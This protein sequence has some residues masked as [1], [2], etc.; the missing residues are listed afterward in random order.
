MSARRSPE[1]G[2]SPVPASFLAAPAATVITATTRGRSPVS[3]L[4]T[5]ARGRSPD[6]QFLGSSNARGKSP[7]A[8]FDTNSLW[9]QLFGLSPTRKHVV[10]LVG[11]GGKTSTMF[12]LAKECSLRGQKVICTTTTKIGAPSK[13]LSPVLLIAPT[14]QEMV[15]KLGRHLVPGEICTVAYGSVR[16][17]HD[18]TLMKLVGI[19]AE[20]V[21]TLRDFADVV[22]IEADGAAH[23]PF[24]MPAGHEPV[25]PSC[26]TE[27]LVLIGTDALGAPIQMGSVHRPELLTAALG[28]PKGTPLTASMIARVACSPVG[29]LKGYPTF[30]SP[31]TPA[32]S[33]VVVAPSSPAS[34]TPLTPTSLVSPPLTPTG[35]TSFSVSPPATP[36]QLLRQS[37][38]PLPCRLV[39]I[40]NKADINPAGAVELAQAL[41]S[42]S[43]MPDL[44]LGSSGKTEGVHLRWDRILVATLR[45]VPT[46][47]SV[48]HRLFSWFCGC[49]FVL[50][51]DD[52]KKLLEHLDELESAANAK[53]IPIFDPME[54][55]VP[56]TIENHPPS[57][58]VPRLPHLS[59][60]AGF[61]YSSFDPEIV[62][63]VSVDTLI[64]ILD[65]LQVCPRH[66]P[67]SSADAEMRRKR[68]EQQALRD[69]EALEQTQAIPP[70]PLP[71]PELLEFVV[72]PA[73]RPPLT[74]RL[75]NPKSK[76]AIAQRSS[77]PSLAED[78]APDEAATPDPPMVGPPPT[79]G[80]PAP[81]FSP[82]MLQP[83]RLLAHRPSRMA[84]D[85]PSVRTR[86]Q[87]PTTSCPFGTWATSP[88]AA[89]F[90]VA[91]C[92]PLRIQR[93]APPDE[94]VAPVA[95][96][97][98]LVKEP[99]SAPP[100]LPSPAAASS[101]P[102]TPRPM[103]PGAN[104]KACPVSRPL[105]LYT[106][107]DRALPGE[108]PAAPPPPPPGGFPMDDLPPP[109]TAS[110]KCK[111]GR[112]SRADRG[113]GPRGPRGG[114]HGGRS[115]MDEAAAG[116]PGDLT[117]FGSAPVAAWLRTGVQQAIH[118]A[119]VRHCGSNGEEQAM[120]IMA[121]MAENELALRTAADPRG[122]LRAQCHMEVAMLEQVLCGADPESRAHFDALMG[123]LAAG[124]E[125]MVRPPSPQQP[126][127]Q[128]LP[129]PH[130]GRQDDVLRLY[131]PEEPFG[132]PPDSPPPSSPA[133]APAPAPL[134]LAPPTLLAPVRVPVPAPA[135]T[136][137]TTMRAP[138]PAPAPALASAA[139]HTL[140][141]APTHA[142]SPS[143]SPSPTPAPA[144]HVVS[145]IRPI[146]IT[147][148]L[149]IPELIVP[150]PPP[151]PVHAAH[152]PHPA[153]SRQ[154]LPAHQPARTAPSFATPPN[155]EGLE[156]A[157]PTPQQP[158]QPLALSRPPRAARRGSCADHRPGL[159]GHARFRHPPPVAGRGS[160]SAFARPA[161][162]GGSLP[163]RRRPNTGHRR[164]LSQARG[165]TTIHPACPWATHGPTRA[166]SCPDL[167]WGAPSVDAGRVAR[168]AGGTAVPLPMP[169]CPWNLATL[170]M[171]LTFMQLAILPTG[172]PALLFHSWPHR[173]EE[174]A[175]HAEAF[176]GAVR[177][178]RFTASA[179]HLRGARLAE[180]LVLALV[181]ALERTH[182]EAKLVAG[183]QVLPPPDQALVAPIFPVPGPE[184][185]AAPPPAGLTDAAVLGVTSSLI[186]ALLQQQQQ[187]QHQQQQQQPVAP[188]GSALISPPP[189]QVALPHLS[190][191]GSRRELPLVELER[192]YARGL[193][194]DTP[195][196]RS[197]YLRTHTRARPLD[198][199]QDE[200][201]RRQLFEAQAAQAESW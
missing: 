61:F 107:L 162:R 57:V 38:I 185:L 117:D 140:A 94:R 114:W 151:A 87:S 156:R 194:E 176:S 6:S 159:A 88:A 200:I 7:D 180:G 131:D 1:R 133:P 163:A 168:A 32:P 101:R 42:H 56:D 147:A 63:F 183:H 167:G 96:D 26:T 70:Q 48:L 18:P 170:L 128:R 97:G 191:E 69:L 186:Q 134:A 8:R 49:F 190:R 174:L 21:A 142:A 79:I 111:K 64:Q 192:L 72:D 85:G 132:E 198:A 173:D 110:R 178:E 43:P 136:P 20:W 74:I 112:R 126:P 122:L 113:R 47:V 144:P 41:W 171:I 195:E 4:A 138:A 123:S 19:P 121:A 77:S 12:A 16:A 68:C 27:M 155:H 78:V 58:P 175:K 145:P 29:L 166:P 90:T 150:L 146:P 93:F 17:P 124:T 34:L 36:T 52:A 44:S 104:R 25:V 189:D 125:Y 76:R 135:H 3:S 9:Q 181:R 179:E 105:V 45:P 149:P 141:H 55:L 2:R 23:L 137:P 81:V 118:E 201:R 80:A 108:V 172:A 35:M 153:S 75:P 62:S 182:L 102:R 82:L 148:C 51:P 99:P 187:Q 199:E 39:A 119:L 5:A 116:A 14:I 98:G 22:I 50:D 24:K 89:T 184:P 59:G 169:T 130:Q 13:D 54:G 40:V 129:L 158:Q 177:A 31:L 103:S 66:P 109:E 196:Y 10:S 165:I 60:L 46:I 37:R 120:S 73:V 28:V 152:P 157:T 91:T 100:A 106:P 164:F 15:E 53:G 197:W 193:K 33:G 115:G 30:E 154:A 127:P 95:M 83:R 188:S 11:G 86:S 139:A 71:F 161:T 92:G 160:P 143:P 65:E 67:V 84:R